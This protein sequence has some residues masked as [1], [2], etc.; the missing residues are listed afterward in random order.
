MKC[1]DCEEELKI[2]AYGQCAI[3]CDINDDGI[4]LHPS[5]TRML[6]GGDIEYE[7]FYCGYNVSDLVTNCSAI[8]QKIPQHDVAV[9]PRYVTPNE[10]AGR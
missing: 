8:E 1:P 10:G 4:L 3:D 2:T 7:C 6:L 9:P 5:D